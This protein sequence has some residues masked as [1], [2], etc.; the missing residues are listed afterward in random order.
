MNSSK[1][2]QKSRIDAV[3]M[4]HTA[5]AAHIGSALS[6]IDILAVLYSD[7]LNIDTS[8]LQQENR[9]RFILSKGHGC[10]AVY[11]ILANM[12]VINKKMIKEYGQNSS[13]LMIFESMFL[14]V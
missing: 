10:V 5:K 14:F 13:I 2:A 6:I 11:S 7:I 12:N 4:V 1:L 9:D 8:N 3:K